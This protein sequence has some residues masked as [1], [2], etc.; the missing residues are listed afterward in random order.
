MILSV[1]RLARV[2]SRC[3]P[4]WTMCVEC[5]LPATPCIAGQGAVEVMHAA[6]PY[7]LTS[8]TAFSSNCRNPILTSMVGVKHFSTI[9]RLFFPRTMLI[10]VE[11]E[12]QPN[13]TIRLHRVPPPETAGKPLLNNPF[14]AAARNVAP[15]R[16]DF[17]K[18]RL[19]TSSLTAAHS[20][21]SR[22]RRI[23]RRIYIRHLHNG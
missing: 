4:A 7:D 1:A 19:N 15:H 11:I 6:S 8:R 22:F 10:I 18:A 23:N 9:A 12:Y 13:G 21:H 14:S 5:T 20:C 16:R 17:T 3:Q 2:V